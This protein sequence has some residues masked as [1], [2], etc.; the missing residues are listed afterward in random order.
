MSKIILSETQSA[1]LQ[2]VLSGQAMLTASEVKDLLMSVDGFTDEL[3]ALVANSILSMHETTASK[4]ASIVGEA[5]VSKS[6]LGSI[7]SKFRK[8]SPKPKYVRVDKVQEVVKDAIE[9]FSKPAVL[10]GWET[11]KPNLSGW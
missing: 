7:L 8:P 3:A 1:N 5:E 10:T 2:T 4:V 6:F 9:E 11:P